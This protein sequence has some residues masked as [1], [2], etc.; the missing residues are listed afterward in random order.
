MWSGLRGIASSIATGFARRMPTSWALNPRFNDR[1]VVQR[2]VNQTYTGQQ[3]TRPSYGS[4]PSFPHSAG[5]NHQKND[6]SLAV[7]VQPGIQNRVQHLFGDTTPVIT[8]IAPP[9]NRIAQSSRVNAATS[10]ARPVQQ[11]VVNQHTT[12]RNNHLMDDRIPD[13]VIK[14]SINTYQQEQRKR[15]A[16]AQAR[17]D[18]QNPQLQRDIA[19]AIKASKE[20]FQAKT[21]RPAPQVITLTPGRSNLAQALVQSNQQYLQEQ[22]A[23]TLQKSTVANMLAGYGYR[24]MDVPRDGNCF[25]HALAAHYSERVTTEVMRKA[26]AGEAWRYFEQY[27][28]GGRPYPGFDDDLYKRLLVEGDLNKM[29]GSGHYGDITDIIF[30]ARRLQRPV[31]VVNRFGS[32]CLAVDS[33][34][35]PMLSLNS[36]AD[37]SRLPA[38]TINMVWDQTIENEPG[39][40][41]FMLATR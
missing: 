37:A 15:A 29:F 22:D 30:A 11:A 8:P 5:I 1:T 18:A 26:I 41:H 35:R 7:N 19:L 9:S 31:M 10:A 2:A 34:G 14:D 20:T 3:I 32:S 36:L 27:L 38:N 6:S 33:Q 13:S 25:Y 39:S 16:E 17:A 40:N 24:F 23:I 21:A 12:A 4:R 28:Q